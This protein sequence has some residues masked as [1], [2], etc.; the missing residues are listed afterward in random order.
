M[1]GANFF[2]GEDT[3]RE[4]PPIVIRI[5]RVPNQNTAITAM[6]LRTEPV[7]P[8]TVTYVYSQPHGRNA[9]LIPSKSGV[10]SEFWRVE[11]REK[12]RDMRAES[13]AVGFVLKVIK[14][15]PIPQ[16]ISSTPATSEAI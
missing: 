6:P 8:A 16:I 3:K 5:G 7:P 12:N 2:S 1:V 10:R 14:S 9:E 13:A 4:R 15:V 11:S